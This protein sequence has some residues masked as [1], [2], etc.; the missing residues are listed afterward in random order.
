MGQWTDLFL[1]LPIPEHWLHALL[2]ITFGLHLLFVLLMLGTAMLGLAFF[3]HARLSGDGGKQLWNKQVVTSHLGLKSLAVV[4]GVAPLLLIQIRYSHAFFTITGLFSYAW[5]AVIP[6]LIFAFLAI[7]A[8][9]HKIASWPLVPF[10]CGV[11]GVG[12]LLT[13]PAVFTGVLALME[14][15]EFWPDFAAR[16]ARIDAGFAPHWLFRYLHVLGAALVFGAAFHLFFSA[17]EQPDKANRL[18]AW[19]FGATLFQVV[20]GIPLV[21]SVAD[22]LNWPVLFAV[23][24]GTA[25]A[26]LTLWSFRPAASCAPNPRSGHLL[27]LLPVLFV[28]MLV[29][30]QFLQDGA[31]APAHA[32]ARERR[33]E[34]S[35]ALTPYREAAL[36]AFKTKLQTVYNNGA[37]IYDGACLPCH[38]Q[39]G[40]GD[41]PAARRLLIPAEDLTA[42]RADRGYIYNILTNGTNGSAMPYFRLFD[43]DKLE[44]LLDALASRFSMFDATTVSAHGASAEAVTLWD[45]TCATCHGKD[46]MPNAYGQTLLPAPPNL[47]HFSL[48]PERA[49]AIITEGYPGTVMQP[50]RALPE[51]VR[52]ELVTISNGFRVV[53]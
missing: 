19:V 22:G 47:K 25:A 17:K 12:A 36:V 51:A 40:R 4:L 8:F 34:K 15:Q 43:R 29:T 26:M 49:L 38:G 20:V 28:A 21:F 48:T 24:I 2:F 7:D 27:L 35:K 41:G 50:Y 31:L 23:T 45:T 18:R 11:L 37:T 9:G 32:L 39:N 1:S 33:D 53:R 5:L 44:S 42:I 46:G 30:R 10:V 6:L 16:G 14:R 52:Q 3:L 13:V